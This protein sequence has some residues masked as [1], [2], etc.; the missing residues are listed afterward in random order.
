MWFLQVPDR[1]MCPYPQPANDT[2]AIILDK[3][4]TGKETGLK[5]TAAVLC[6]TMAQHGEWLSHA[7][8]N[9]AI[10]VS[11]PQADAKIQVHRSMMVRMQRLQL[12]CY[13][14][15]KPSVL[16]MSR[17]TPK[18][19]PLYSVDLSAGDEW[20]QNCLL[21]SR[22]SVELA[23]CT[24]GPAACPPG[25]VV[26]ATEAASIPAAAAWVRTLTTSATLRCCYGGQ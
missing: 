7:C 24:P 25:P 4:R 17:Y 1:S 26:R 22:E 8:M 6:C 19:E 20:L 9:P 14:P 2:H 10:P 21:D 16:M 3:Q 11:F 5:L 12:L 23:C 18:A 15:M 13:S